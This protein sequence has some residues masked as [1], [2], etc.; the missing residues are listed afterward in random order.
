MEESSQSASSNRISY[1]D[2]RSPHGFIVSPLGGKLYSTE[3]S[4][5]KL[6]LNVSNGIDDGKSSNRFGVVKLLP[7]YYNGSIQ[8]GDTVLVHHNVF[9]KYNDYDGVERFSVDFFEGEDYLIK[10]DQIFAHSSGESWITTG[11]NILVKPHDHELHG[12]VA[13]SNDSVVLKPGD[14]IVFTPE[15][16][17]EFY[18]DGNLFYKMTTDDVCMIR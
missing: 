2:M 8:V 11:D 17:Y 15:S 10:D 4:S 3:T 5:S 18:I 7:S 1:R 14:E 6:G 9:R 16:E 12:I 13:Y